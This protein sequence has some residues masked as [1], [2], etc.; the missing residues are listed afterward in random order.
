MRPAGW[1]G[2]LHLGRVDAQ[3][4]VDCR[5]HLM[6]VHG[7]AGVSQAVPVQ[8]T[9]GLAHIHAAAGHEAGGAFA[10]VADA[11]AVLKTYQSDHGLAST[12][13]TVPPGAKCVFEP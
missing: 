10:P 4:M 6:V 11:S 1:I 5:Q 9:E 13:M 12:S 2:D 7:A 3:V 8:L